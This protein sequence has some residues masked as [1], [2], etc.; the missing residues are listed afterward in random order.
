MGVK[1]NSILIKPM[2]LSP[3]N[4]SIDCGLLCLTASLYSERKYEPDMLIIFRPDDEC[5]ATALLPTTVSRWSFPSTPHSSLLL[6]AYQSRTRRSYHQISFF[7]LRITQYKANVHDTYA[8]SQHDCRMGIVLLIRQIYITMRWINVFFWSSIAS[9]AYYIT[10]L[11]W[12]FSVSKL[13]WA[14]ACMEIGNHPID[15]PVMTFFQ[16]W[17]WWPWPF[18]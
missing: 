10:I 6:S 9:N 17:C 18:F 4:T 15:R 12:L 3:I 8:H 14:I 2:K 11:K 13:T 1:E 16:D 5:N 7:F